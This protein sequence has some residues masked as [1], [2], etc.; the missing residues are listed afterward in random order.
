MSK[1]HYPTST[2]KLF[3][4]NKVPIVFTK[5]GPIPITNQRK[6]TVRKL[7]MEQ[8]ITIRKRY[9]P[10]VVSQSFLAKEYGVNPATISRIIREISYKPKGKDSGDTL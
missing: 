9:I 7:T 5:Q 3:I 1:F 6:F 4:T 2:T 10:G 8:A